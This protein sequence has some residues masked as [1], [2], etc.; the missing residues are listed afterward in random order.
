MLKETEQMRDRKRIWVA[1]RTPWV[2]TFSIVGHDPRNGDLGIAV[3]SK[4]LAVGAVVPWARAGVGAV[5]TQSWANTTYGPAALD[6]L[7]AGQEP[8]QVIDTLVATDEGHTQR[9]VGVVDAQGRAATFTGSE[10]FAWAG[11]RTGPHFAAQ[12]NILVSQETVDAMAETFLEQQM[13]GAGELSDHLVA[14]LAAGQ[15]AGGDSRGMQSAALLVVRAAG[16]YAGFNDRYIDLRVDDHPYPI[17]ELRRILDLHQLYFL[18]TDPAT[19]LPLSG[20]TLDEVRLLLHEGGYLPLVP[21]DETYDPVTQEAFSAFVHRE[22]LEDRL[23][24]DARIDPVVLRYLRTHVE[25]IA[26]ARSTQ[27]EPPHLHIVRPSERPGSHA[28]EVE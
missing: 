26:G 1:P 8:Q 6:L 9:Q 28:P 16:G 21:P 13:T 25:Q 23:Q 10:C 27:A 18:P 17:A 11:G 7:A 4:F 20:V 5:A 22:N 15:A 24:E 3:Q 12:G 2:A 19:L 14:A